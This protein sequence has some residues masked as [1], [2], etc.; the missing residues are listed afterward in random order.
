MRQLITRIDDR[1]L[2]QLKARAAQE[3]RSVNALVTELLSAAV[4]SDDERQA[5]RS[6]ADALGIAVTPGVERR[7]PSRDAAIAST[8]GA[9]RAASEALDADRAR[10]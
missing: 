8:R 9:G 10:R 5:V 7:P 1:L 4:A 6:R 2:Q 3:G